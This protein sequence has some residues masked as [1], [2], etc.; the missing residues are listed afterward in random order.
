[1]KSDNTKMDFDDRETSD[2]L[3]IKAATQEELDEYIKS[4]YGEDEFNRL[5]G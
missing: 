4:V 1:M 3:I 5:F 2:D